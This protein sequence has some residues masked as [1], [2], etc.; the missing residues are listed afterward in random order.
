[1]YGAATNPIDRLGLHAKVLAFV[2]P[3]TGQ[4]MS[5]TVPLPSSFGQLFAK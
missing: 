4:K 1:M 5:F 3:T 2:H